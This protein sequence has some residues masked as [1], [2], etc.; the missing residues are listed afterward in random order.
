MLNTLGGLI[1]TT[2][3]VLAQL[4][5]DVSGF[6]LGTEFLSALARIVATLLTDLVTTLLGGFFGFGA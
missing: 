6:L 1:S 4:F 2:P 5:N 3:P